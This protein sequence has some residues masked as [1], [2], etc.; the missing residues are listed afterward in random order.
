[1]GRGIEETTRSLKEQYGK[2]FRTLVIGPAGENRVPFANILN[3][4][5]H[6]FGR[7]GFGAVMGAKN[8]KAI[9]VNG[10]KRSLKMADPERFEE[11]RAE[12]NPRI[13]EGLISEVLHDFGTAGSLEGHVYD[14][15]VPIK[16]W[17]SN[18]WEEMAEALTGSTLEEKYLTRRATCAHCAI[19]CKRVVAVKEGPFA[20]PEG[21]GPEYE[22][23]ASFGALLGAM[24]LAA[25]CKAGRMCNDLGLDTISAGATIAWAMEA[26]ERGDL[27]LARYGGHGSQMGGYGAGDR[28]FAHDRKKGGNNRRTPFSRQ[29]GR[30]QADR[31]RFHRLYRPEQGPGGAHA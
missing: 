13:R 28:P 31:Q 2:K 11:L 12:L 15:D 18:F 26:F 25:T 1:M 20:V 30:G 9:V 27:T 7:A 21:P 17:T 23:I 29:P 3:E 24:D 8:L 10:T 22:T 6:A 4:S 19:A 16:N 5:H 14:G